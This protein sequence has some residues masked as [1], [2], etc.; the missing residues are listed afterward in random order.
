[1]HLNKTTTKA[2]GTSKIVSSSN[3]AVQGLGIILSKDVNFVNTTVNAITHWY[4]YQPIASSKW[5]LTIR[6]TLKDLVS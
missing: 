6:R 1:M 3:V 5:Y 4:I 2:D